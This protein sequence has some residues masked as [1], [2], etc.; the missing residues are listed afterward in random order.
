MEAVALL[1]AIEVPNVALLVIPSSA[2]VKRAIYDLRQFGVDAHGLNLFAEGQGKEHLQGGA[3]RRPFRQ[4]TLLVCTPSTARGIDMPELS[5]VLILGIPDGGFQGELNADTYRHLA[6]RVG[7]FG[8]SGKVVTIVE[9]GRS[10]ENAKESE[11]GRIRQILR[12]NSVKA[13]KLGLFD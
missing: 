2:S 4:P 3:K 5:H 11:I 7:R 10:V 6:G 1:V 12:R 9:E 8:R 13:V